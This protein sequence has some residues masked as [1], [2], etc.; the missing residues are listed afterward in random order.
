MAK[1]KNDHKE[2]R[3]KERDFTTLVEV[4]GLL[5]F[6][7]YLIISRIEDGVRYKFS[8]LKI[9]ISVSSRSSQ[10]IRIDID[11]SIYRFHCSTA[12]LPN[13]TYSPRFV[14]RLGL[15]DTFNAIHLSV[16]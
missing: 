12:K 14:K 13:H 16:S 9:L 6:Y 2:E 3:D 8:C 7:K 4:T 11:L 15:G 10:S 1:K 5:Q